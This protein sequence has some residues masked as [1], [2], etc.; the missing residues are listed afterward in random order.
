MIQSPSPVSSI[1]QISSSI[2][3]PSSPILPHIPHLTRPLSQTIASS[4]NNNSHSHSNNSS[5]N[6]NNNHSNNDSSERSKSQ[7]NKSDASPESNRRNCT[8]RP[9]STQSNEMSPKSYLTSP[10]LAEATISD[11]ESFSLQSSELTTPDTPLCGAYAPLL[12]FEESS[13]SNNTTPDFDVN[14]K[15]RKYSSETEN[16]DKTMAKA[17]LEFD[18][19]KNIGKEYERFEEKIIRISSENICLE[20]KNKYE[21]VTSDMIKVEKIKSQEISPPKPEERKHKRNHQYENIPIVRPEI[22]PRKA[23]VVQAVVLETSFDSKIQPEP[24]SPVN[25]DSI[26]SIKYECISTESSSDSLINL[27]KT[28][29]NKLLLA[30]KSPNPSPVV[31]EFQPNWP[32]SSEIVQYESTENVE[33]AENP[34]INVSNEARSNEQVNNEQ[35][36]MNA[37]FDIIDPSDSNWFEE[38]AS[39]IFN[40]VASNMEGKDLLTDDKADDSFPTDANLIED[41]KS[42]ANLEEGNLIEVNFKNLP[43]NDVKLPKEK[44]AE[45]NATCDSNINDILSDHFE[46]EIPL[47][48]VDLSKN[49]G[50][51]FV[52]DIVNK[53]SEIL[54]E[55]EKK[56]NEIVESKSPYLET[57]IA[58][59]PA[60]EETE[61]KLLETSF[62][63]SNDIE[64][65]LMTLSTSPKRTKKAETKA[66]PKKKLSPQKSNSSGNVRQLLTKFEV[67]PTTEKNLLELKFDFHNYKKKESK[68]ESKIVS[69][70]ENFSRV[71]RKR[72]VEERPRTLERLSTKRRT[73]KEKLELPDTNLGKSK[74]G[75]QID[76]KGTEINSKIGA[77]LNSDLDL[78]DPQR[79]E[80][81]ERYKEKRRTYLREK[82][83]TDSFK[84]DKDDF[85][86][87]FKQKH[88]SKDSQDPKPKEVIEVVKRLPPFE[89]PARKHLPTKSQ[90]STSDK[91]V[92]EKRNPPFEKPARKNPTSKLIEPGSKDFYKRSFS[93]DNTG[94]KFDI[95][96]LPVSSR[97]QSN[98]KS[99]FSRL[100][101]ER[102][103]AGDFRS[104]KT[105]P[106][107]KNLSLDLSSPE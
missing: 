64:T 84:G 30:V 53:T 23:S 13:V 17:N 38:V 29:E 83:H 79:R 72:N 15:T 102:R 59:K 62:D 77:L 57:E 34:D 100:G 49:E 96:S 8:S 68:P 67:S 9:V 44:I 18:K 33:S 14:D 58:G 89:K 87:K 75:S 55:E 32:D 91:S 11:N 19:H 12:D 22:E 99:G 35:E 43:Q 107:K 25:R 69:D 20:L 90:T 85:L 39:E 98:G 45:E 21:N 94:K 54:T 101:F 48:E 71:E 61:K 66:S 76:E 97:D 63:E 47:Q 6:L 42:S 95:S 73:E 70:E 92:L 7:T 5:S 51:N 46:D 81:I 28:D 50:E 52:G 31:E 3:P 78:S 74:S 65:V 40:N 26:I 88:V 82:Y 103:S 86:L 93:M 80:R 4:N 105:S 27:N 2:L 56:Q 104:P 1:S 36:E 16:L 24:K 10:S 41:N 37:D 60:V 106:E